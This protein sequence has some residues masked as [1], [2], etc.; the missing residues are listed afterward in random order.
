MNPRPSIRIGTLIQKYKS[1]TID[2][3]ISDYESLNDD[4]KF[5]LVSDVMGAYAIVDPF[6]IFEKDGH[7]DLFLN[8]M[9]NVIA[10]KGMNTAVNKELIDSL[11]KV[12]VTGYERNRAGF[13]DEISKGLWS[14][15]TD[16]EKYL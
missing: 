15:L 5:N 14:F 12:Y 3:G 4:T 9:I 7:H 16:E 8:A 6:V 13:A 10:T 11:I 1:E 2:K